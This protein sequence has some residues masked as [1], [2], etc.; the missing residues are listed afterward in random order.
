M[1][2]RLL[3]LIL[4]ATLPLHGCKKKEAEPPAGTNSAASV[5][6][7]SARAQIAPP[8]AG[9]RRT[10]FE[11]VTA[12]LDPGG[13]LYVYLSADQWLAGL[14]TN[15]SQ[16]RQLLLSLPGPAAEK[17]VEIDRAF[18]MLTRFVRGSGVEQITGVGLSS[19]PVAEGLFRNKFVVHHREGQGKGFLWSV[20]GQE[21]HALNGQSMMPTNTV[22]AAFGDFNIQDALQMAERELKDSGI[23]EITEALRS[24]P[25][26]F[27]KQTKLSWNDLLNSIGG[28]FG[29][30]VTFDDEKRVELPTGRTKVS[31]PTPGLLVAMKSS[32]P[33]LYEQL[34]TQLQANPKAVTAEEGK[35]KLCWM[36]L[37]VP[38]PVPIQPTIA[39]SGDYFY[40]ASSPEVV[41]AVEAVRQG[42]QPSIKTTREFQ[43]LARHVPVEGNQFAYVDRRL[44]QGFREL[45][46][47]ALNDSGLPAE[48]LEIF[49]RLFGSSQPTHSLAVGTH[50]GTGWETVS[51]GNQDSG[52]A[53]LLLP[54]VGVTA[55]AAGMILPALAK[56]KAKAQTISS[57]NNLKQ[58]A[59]AARIYANDNQNKFPVAATWGDQLTELVGN[60]KVYKAPNDPSPRRCSYAFNSRLSGMDES[61]VNPETVLFFETDEGEWN[62]HGGREIMLRQPRSGGGGN[63]VVGLADGSVHQ[64][65]PARVSSLRWEP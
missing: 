9:G 3:M 60:E 31:I 1:K 22:F 18:D 50:L 24:W 62:Q 54:T 46:Q 38:I 53:V 36:P 64:M 63:F 6:S 45:Q 7:P 47:Q 42:Q 26:V 20:F 16:V 57:V 40:F 58:L 12:R 56:A 32:S 15:I 65:P 39:F 55:V 51:V 25:Q 37:P 23:P 35:L 52:A 43:E 44:G 33:Y 13:S 27:E 2:K 4:V 21:P 10:S 28:E 30:L 5:S 34:A 41:R 48:Q 8:F 61:K 59:L 49:Q 14:S 19:A 17:G 11:E 29:V